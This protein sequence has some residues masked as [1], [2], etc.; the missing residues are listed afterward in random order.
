M[1]AQLDE[2][3]VTDKVELKR[4]VGRGTFT[5]E[6]FDK[7]LPQFKELPVDTKEQILIESKYASYI[8]KQQQQ[9][10]RMKN[11]INIKIPEDFDF[12]KVAGLSNE[13][14]EKLQTFNPPTLFAASEISGVTPAALDILHIYIRMDQK[15][16]R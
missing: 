1:L 11:M 14:I 16:T 15:G 6:K 13:I 7:L 5:I 3:P 4:V 12:S 8:K 2:A 9:I 10:D